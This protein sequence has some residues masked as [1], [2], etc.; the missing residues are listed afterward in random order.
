MT[1]EA[2]NLVKGNRPIVLQVM[3]VVIFLLGW[4]FGCRYFKVPFY[5]IPVP[6]TIGV[7]FYESMMDFTLLRHGWVTI[8][9]IGLG[10]LQ[11]AAAGFVLGMVF[12]EFETLRVIMNPFIMATQVT[13]KTALAPLFIIWF[14]FGI[15]SKVFIV[16]L[17][18]FFPVLV[19]TIA[20]VRSVDAEKIDLMRTYGASRLKI[21]R[22]VKLPAAFPNIFAGLEVASV[23]SVLGAIIGEF[24]GSKSGLGRL[25]LMA[26]ERLDMGLVFS[27]I[28]VLL[29]IGAGLQV[30]GDRLKKRLLF[31][32]GR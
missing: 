16:A 21:I 5:L 14:G 18:A 19:N 12:A 20:G 15:A 22:F 24:V 30:T 31:W 27:S 3:A 8:S 6:S 2:V 11:G 9:E 17:I 10:F 32:V 23:T 29:I 26:G 4:E 28:L 13:P 1:K 7:R 25:I